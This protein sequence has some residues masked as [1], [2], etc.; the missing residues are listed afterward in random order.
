M[1]TMAKIKNGSTY[2]GEHLC[3]NDYYN[4]GEENVKGKWMGKLAE[5]WQL[6]GPIEAGDQGVRSIKKQPSTGWN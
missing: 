3:K 5:Y 2:L 4:K 1:F 6:S